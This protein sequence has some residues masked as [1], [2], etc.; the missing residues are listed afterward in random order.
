VRELAGEPVGL[1]GA[2]ELI[3]TLVYMGAVEHEIIDSGMWDYQLWSDVQPVRVRRDGQ[4]VPLDVYQRLVNW[5]FSLNV[6]RTLLTTD[7][8]GLAL[9][10]AGAEAF[11]RFRNDLLELQRTLDAEPFAAWR[12][13]PKFL[14]AN[15]NY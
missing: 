4:L 1:A 15:I 6:D 11:R 14:K 2:A 8:S 12:M 7:F 13:E 3:A 5:N 9:D 10:P